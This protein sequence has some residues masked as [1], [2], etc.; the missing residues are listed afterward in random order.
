MLMC[1]IVYILYECAHVRIACLCMCH[2]SADAH[3]GV[4]THMRVFI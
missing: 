1:I 3:A 2:Q 4:C